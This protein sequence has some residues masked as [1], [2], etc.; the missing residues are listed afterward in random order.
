MESFSFGLIVAYVIPGFIGLAG[1][2]P[3]VPMIGQWLTPVHG[4]TGL[5]PPIYAILAA[6]AVG[7]VVSCFRWLFVDQIHHW[8]GLKAPPADFKALDGRVQGFDYLVQNHFRYYEFCGNTLVAGLW[9][10]CLNRS[11]QTSPLLG[12][13]TDLGMAILS[14]VLFAASRDALAKY[15]QRTHRL[16]SQ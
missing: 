5:G 7:L 12:I 15:Y 8:S 11:L 16:L 6:T 4:D 2:M 1:L 10:Y 3:L 9:A 13:G 14:V